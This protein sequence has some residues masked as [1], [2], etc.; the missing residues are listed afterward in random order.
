MMKHSFA[1]KPEILYFERKKQKMP[2]VCV[3]FEISYRFMKT[4]VFD[5]SFTILVV[6]QKDKIESTDEDGH[7]CED[8][9]GIKNWVLNTI[10]TLRQRKDFEI[11]AI[12][13]TSYAGALIHLD[14]NEN[15][16]LPVYNYTKKIPYK[17]R[18]TFLDSYGYRPKFQFQVQ[19]P[20]WEIE[21][22]AFQLFWVKSAKT[23]AYKK[24]KYSVPLTQYLQG[25][26][27]KDYRQEL[28]MLGCHSGGWNFTDQQMHKWISDEHLHSFQLPY[29]K[30][31]DTIHAEGIVI[32]SGIHNKVAT[33]LALKKSQDQKFVLLSTGSW[34][35]CINPFNYSL[36]PETGFSNNS[37]SILDEEGKTGRMSRLFSG[38]EHTRQIRHLANHF[39]VD[40]DYF[41]NLKFD[42]QIIRKLRKDFPQVTPESTE[43][44]GMMDCPFMERNINN[45]QRTEE[46][47]HQFIIDLIAQQIA[48]IRHTFDHQNNRKIFVDGGLAKNEIFMELLGEAFHDKTVY[49]I[50]N[51][52]TSA[53]GA[54]AA[55][56]TSWGA[57]VS[58]ITPSLLEL[59]CD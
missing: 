31:D 8:L 21:N 1:K 22:T 11:V 15:P 28:T 20:D 36:T 7:P 9:I 42:R 37:H 6:E 5:Q 35:L 50:G 2:K 41:L 19:V 24:I 47:Y 49:T 23:E 30:P 58:Y 3:V 43:T 32:G 25:L 29:A 39:N 53:L 10:K 56:A 55:I 13:F 4:V 38:D 14:Q 57:D 34:T 48:S 26:F 33:C 12:N 18:K 17:V 59:S 52:H 51:E 16:V 40:E 45:F 44:G 27:T 54:A 46:A